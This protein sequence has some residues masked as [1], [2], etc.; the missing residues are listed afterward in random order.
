ME[1]EH[2]LIFW[3]IADHFQCWIGVREPNPYSQ[4]YMGAADAIPKPEECKAKTADNPDSNLKGLV[5]DPTVRPDA[6]RSGSL[7]RAI[8][9]WQEKF[10]DAQGN[11]P[12]GFTVERQGPERGLVRQGGMKIFSDY[13]LMTLM[14]S[15]EAG[16]FLDTNADQL[17]ALADKVTAM[18]N[19]LLPKPMIQHG[20]EFLFDGVGGKHGEFVLWFGPGQRRFTGPSSV[21]KDMKH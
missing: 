10:V 13:D 20:P 6:F 12:E 11:L 9:I 17:Q 16:E 2:K 1:E 18:L 7:S 15:N 8:G 14:Q 3:E 19:R 21:D 5:V 4:D